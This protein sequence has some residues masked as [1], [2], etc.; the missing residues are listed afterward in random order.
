MSSV[1]ANAAV[2]EICGGRLILAEK[3]LFACEACG[4]NYP[5]EW[6][7][8]KVQEISGTV[9]V[10]GPVEVRGVASAENL[11][12]RAQAFFDNDSIGLATEYCN[13]VLDLEPNHSRTLALLNEIS[14]K[15]KKQDMET[16]YWL[17]MN[18]IKEAGGQYSNY[19]ANGWRMS[20]EEA[21]NSL[22]RL[23][24][25]DE[26][27]AV[28][29]AFSG[30]PT[31][32]EIAVYRD[33]ITKN[34]VDAFAAGIF[35]FYFIEKKDWARAKLFLSEEF[36]TFNFFS[37]T[38]HYEE[39]FSAILTHEE[40]AAAFQSHIQDP[41]QF[42]LRSAVLA[43]HNGVELALLCGANLN[44]CLVNLVKAHMN[45]NNH[46]VHIE[47]LVMLGADTKQ[48]IDGASLGKYLKKR[49]RAHK[50]FEEDKRRIQQAILILS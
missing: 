43:P 24:E 32:D 31:D 17:L 11:L 49:L 1:K 37:R 40:L 19:F 23:K 29:I 27:Y 20:P 10:D 28:T 16:T 38:E 9:K 39:L 30:L 15:N 47:A 7:R 33:F 3:D 34:S 50:G 4:A 13:K 6:V 2:C 46:I 5:K 22:Q 8:A 45:P 42:L 48:K 21:K 12:I 35:I 44:S 36:S 14:K 18:R 41:E 25:A 26:Y